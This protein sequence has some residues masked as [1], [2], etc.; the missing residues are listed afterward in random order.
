MGKKTFVTHPGQLNLF[1][2]I[3]KISHEEKTL[4]SKAGSFNIEAQIRAMLSDALKKCPLSREVVA[5][6]MSEL[7][8]VEI[9]KSQLNSSS[10]LTSLIMTG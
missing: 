3:K 5:G 2:I 9:T 7:V 4:V 1:D 8:G 6:K 10:P